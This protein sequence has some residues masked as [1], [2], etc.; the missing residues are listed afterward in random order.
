MWRSMPFNPTFDE[1][2]QKALR[3][4]CAYLAA[5][6]FANL[7]WEVLQLPLYTLWATGSPGDQAFAIVHCTAG[8]ILISIAALS[9]ALLVFG[10]RRWPDA[11]FG[12]VAAATIVIGAGYTI[13]SEWLNTSVLSNW[14]YSDLMP[15]VPVLGTG[16]APLLQWLIVPAIAL[17]AAKRSSHRA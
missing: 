12:R 4:F 15:I 9:T 16:V 17:T 7:V 5:G 2:T 3:A 14:S 10:K 11:H 8:D 6:T 13:Y 1:P